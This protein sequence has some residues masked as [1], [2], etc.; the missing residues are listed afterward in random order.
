MNWLVRDFLLLFVG[1]VLLAGGACGRVDGVLG[2]GTQ[3]RTELVEYKRNRSHD[4]GDG[5]DE[6]ATPSDGES[7]RAVCL[8]VVEHGSGDEWECCA[9][10]GSKKVVSRIDTSDGFRIT[11]T[12]VR[13]TGLKEQESSDREKRRENDR[14]DPVD[15]SVGCP[16]KA[17]HADRDSPRPQDGRFQPLL[18]SHLA[19]VS[20]EQ[21]SIRV[22]VPENEGD[23]SQNGS[24]K[25][26]HEC[27]TE[28]ARVEAIRLH[29][30]NRKG[31]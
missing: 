28:F 11:V 20:I 9:D 13:E 31:F 30:D 19:T 21:R 17:K 22:L 25:N 4:D 24:Y 26:A 12:Q 6:N 27:K 18:R 23:I 8:E 3:L 5:A 29:K 7:F 10:R 14:H 2:H 1:V 16:T 15:A